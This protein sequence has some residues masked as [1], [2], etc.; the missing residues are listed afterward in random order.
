MP[1]E[2][3][4]RLEESMREHTEIYN[5]ITERR[6]MDANNLM[7]DHMMLQGMRLPQLLKA[8]ED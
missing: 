7:R 8:L 4:G 6:G 5:A 2:V 3:V 1:Y